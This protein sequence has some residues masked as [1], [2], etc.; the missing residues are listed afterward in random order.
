MQIYGTNYLNGTKSCRMQ[1]RHT[2]S[3]IGILQVPF[4]LKKK[5]NSFDCDE[6]PSRVYREPG[7]R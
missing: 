6:F 5:S 2:L 7:L 3:L 4:K 1:I